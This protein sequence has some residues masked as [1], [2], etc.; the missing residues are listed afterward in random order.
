VNE[1]NRLEAFSDGVM[2]IA[3][4]LLVL[5]LVVPTR[6]QIADNKHTLAQALGALWPSFAAYVVSFLIIGIIWV[7]HH[8]L[9]GMLARVERVL[10]FVNLLLLMLVSVIPFPT[11]L[12]AEYLTAGTR[13]SHVAAAIYSATMLATAVVYTSLFALATRRA[14]L[15][16]PGVDADA[17]R[18]SLPRFGLGVG[19]YGL[20]VVLSFI[21]APL[22][23]LTH[24][25]IAVYYVF[26]QTGARRGTAA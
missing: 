26:D 10:L 16:A 23:L 13:D 17:V 24:F 3:I 8:T 20:T 7:N 2:A 5:D 15:L 22:T 21:S 4:T 14:D 12:L 1:K 11:R 18:R 9:F 6:E 19:V 25:L